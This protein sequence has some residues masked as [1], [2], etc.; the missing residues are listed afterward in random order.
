MSNKRQRGEPLIRTLSATYPDRFVLDAHAHSWSQLLYASRGVMVADT[1]GGSW[2][3]PPHR[4]QWLPAE[5]R[6]RV[7]MRGA[8]SMRTI[9]FA[10]RAKV[11]LDH[12]CVVEIPPLLRELIIHCA[13]LG[14]LDAKNA[15]EARLAGL[16]V[17]LVGAVPAMPLALPLPR[18]PRALHVARALLRDPSSDDGRRRSGASTR[19]LERLFL[20]ETGMTLGRWRQQARLLAAITKLAEG[21]PVTSVALDVGYATPSAFIAMFKSALGTTPSR[22]FAALSRFTQ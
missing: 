2:V 1:D 18:D 10:A 8:V 4:A 22:F 7:T 21:K 19:T 13:S 20:S 12:V 6:H 11:P 3:V 9:Y 17:D 5:T 15:H 14:R 16:L